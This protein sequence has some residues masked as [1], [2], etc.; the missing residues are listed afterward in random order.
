MP[1]IDYLRLYGAD[2]AKLLDHGE[3]LLDMGL[4][5][6]PLIGDESKLGRT[7]DELSPRL[8]ER[9][10]RRGGQPAAG[11]DR[12]VQGFDLL[13]GGVQVNP[14]RIDRLFG[15]VSGVGAPGSIAGRL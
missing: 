1:L 15:G 10:E 4:Y 9:V 14:H 2:V 3:Q 13:S 12:F 8:R 5:R 11:S 6:E 7:V